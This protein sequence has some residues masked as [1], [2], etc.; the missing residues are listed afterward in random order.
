MGGSEDWLAALDALQRGDRV[1]LV[2][3]TRVITGYLARFGAYDL[4][5]SWDDLCQEVLMALIASVRKGALREP[6]AF[7]SYAGT[8][9][10]N[11]LADWLQRNRPTATPVPEGVRDT[12]NP[13]PPTAGPAD[14]DIRI[15]LQRALTMLP[16]RQRQVMETVYFQGRTYEEASQQLGIPLGTLKR[17]LTDGLAELRDRIGATPRRKR[18]DSA[19]A[20]DVSVSPA[21]A[22]PPR[23]ARDDRNA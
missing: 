18:S 2:K 20:T 8:I 4:R 6:R 21:A 3:V 7:V 15:D 14:P 5:D 9:T 13:D 12:A 10:R 11:K 19:A 23:G 16:D 22:A 1:A 17:L